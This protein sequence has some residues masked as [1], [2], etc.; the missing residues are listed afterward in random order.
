MAAAPAAAGWSG[1]DA[2]SAGPAAG[3]VRS[4]AGLDLDI[5]RFLQDLR[6]QPL[7]LLMVVASAWWFKGL[8]LLG[9]GLVAD[10]CR[11]RRLPTAF[12]FGAAAYAVASVS[13]DLVKRAVDR[14]RP[15][16]ADEAIQAAI[17][18]PHTAAMPSGHAATA[19]AVAVC[20]GM[21]HPRL[22][23]PLL[24]A[25]GVVAFSRVY[26]GVHYPTDVLVGAGIGVLAGLAGGTLA[27]RRTEHQEQGAA[28]AVLPG[29]RG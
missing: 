4:V 8:V 1:P 29:P 24:V 17:A 10:L 25:A 21:I 23:V 26:L 27:R 5:V 19:V 2:A 16:V 3:T 22:R 28:E 12:L 13:T 9:I 15:P 20:V 14:S 18:L 6:F 7:T 11:G